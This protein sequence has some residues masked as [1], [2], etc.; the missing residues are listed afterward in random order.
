MNLGPIVI[1]CCN[2]DYS[3][4]VGFGTEI[5][6]P[7]FILK[8]TADG[9]IQAEPSLKEVVEYL[10][11]CCYNRR[12]RDLV[13]RTEQSKQLTVIFN[14]NDCFRFG[15]LVL[16][17]G[18]KKYQLKWEGPPSPDFEQL[19]YEFNNSQLMRLKAFW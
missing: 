1:T 17:M 12:I 7:T 8:I 14:E 4:P 5:Q 13:V 6:A 11:Y 18:P 19:S 3:F 10:V 15:Y 9:Y 16:C 2:F